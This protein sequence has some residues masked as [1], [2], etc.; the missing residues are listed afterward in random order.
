MVHSDFPSSTTRATIDAIHQ[1]DRQARAGKTDRG[2]LRA[3]LSRAR[4]VGVTAI[5][6]SRFLVVRLAQR[7]SPS[8]N[9][10]ACRRVPPTPERSGPIVQNRFPK[11]SLASR[12]RS[13]HDVVLA[14]IVW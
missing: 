1:S 6:A 2:F 9:Q 4:R 11:L 8:A 7:A 3:R 12:A 10:Q 5:R 13:A 14:F